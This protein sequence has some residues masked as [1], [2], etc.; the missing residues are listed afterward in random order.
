MRKLLTL[1]ALA[2]MGLWTAC[3]QIPEDNVNSRSM[4]SLSIKATTLPDS[5]V[6]EWDSGSDAEYEMNGTQIQSRA[7]KEAATR[8]AFYLLDESGTKVVSQEKDNSDSE[9]MSL[10]V[11]VPVGTYQLVAFAHNGS[12]DVSVNA[13]AAVAPTGKLTDSFLYYKVLTLDEE[14]DNSQSIVLDRCVAKFSLVHT[15]AIPEGASSVEFKVS[16]GAK[17][18][19]AKTGLGAE[20]VEHTVVINIPERLIGTKDNSFAFYIFLTAEKSSLDISVVSKDAN[21]NKITSYTFEG[22]EMEVNM[23]TIYTGAFFHSDQ[24]I[25]AS[26]NSEWKDSNEQTF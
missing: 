1:I 25:S 23:Q 11:E 20:A 13:N 22:V 10:N 18:L 8:M 21:G 3:Q 17:V 15:D 6:D 9:Y 26:I 5:E 14:S 2:A 24:K 19:N 12:S 7:E 4:T 16:G